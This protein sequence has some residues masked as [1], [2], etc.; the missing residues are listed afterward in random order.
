MKRI[1]ACLN[2]VGRAVDVRNIVGIVA[3][4]FSLCA[5]GCATRSAGVHH[6][7]SFGTA[8]IDREVKILDF[9]YGDYAGL[10]TRATK[11]EVALERIRQGSVVGTFPLGDFLYV[12]WRKVAD[13]SVHEKRVD[14]SMIAPDE[15]VNKELH[16][17]FKNAELYVY[18]I[19]L[20]KHH[21]PGAA[22]CP[23]PAYEIFQCTTVY[24]IKQS[25]F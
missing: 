21:K 17:G 8:G 22:D 9:Q 12:R 5:S 16:F 25:N 23:A 1:L 2:M 10:P 4:S 3:I 14:L 13:G 7:F 6:G 20:K 19:D 18:V 15:M 11:E 24:P